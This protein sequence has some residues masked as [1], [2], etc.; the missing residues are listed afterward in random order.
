MILNFVHYEYTFV[1]LILACQLYILHIKLREL[2][3][4][5]DVFMCII[6]QPHYLRLPISRGAHGPVFYEHRHFLESYD[7][8]PIR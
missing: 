5:I 2:V 6:V 7:Q 3:H 1:L 4:E 8:R